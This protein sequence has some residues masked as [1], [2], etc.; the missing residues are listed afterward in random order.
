MISRQERDEWY[1]FYLF[2]CRVSLVTRPLSLSLSQTCRPP[3]ALK[4]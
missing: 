1:I 4:F 3:F 2:F